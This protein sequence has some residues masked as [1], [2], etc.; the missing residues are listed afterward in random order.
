MYKADEVDEGNKVDKE[1]MDKLDNFDK[2]KVDKVHTC[3]RVHCSALR[4]HHCYQHQIT[5]VICFLLLYI[6]MFF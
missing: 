2:G 5:S 6:N 1:K 4:H 3:T